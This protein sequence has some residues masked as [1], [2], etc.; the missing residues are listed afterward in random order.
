MQNIVFKASN[1]LLFTLESSNVG[2]RFAELKI[3]MALSQ[4]LTKF[5][6]L[7]YEKTENPL[8]FKNGLPLLAGIREIWLQFQSIPE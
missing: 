7:P 5:Q 4:V 1:V 2:K 6:I 3:K 8:T